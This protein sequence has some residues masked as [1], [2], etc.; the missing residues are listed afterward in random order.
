MNRLRGKRALLKAVQLYAKMG[1]SEADLKNAASS[2][3]SQVP[4]GLFGS[5]I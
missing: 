4:A 3:Q 5:A 2:I 1:L